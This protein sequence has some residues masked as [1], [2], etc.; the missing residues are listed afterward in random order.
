[1]LLDEPTQSL[2]LHQAATVMEV[3][4][5]KAGEGM[6]VVAVMHDLNLAALFCDRLI[7]LQAGKIVADGLPAELLT[8]KLISSV[9]GDKIEVLVH[10]ET[11]KPLVLSRK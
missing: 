10:P 1:M 9:Y 4:A 11:K 2:D 3:L 8:Q 7:L 6:R 5:R